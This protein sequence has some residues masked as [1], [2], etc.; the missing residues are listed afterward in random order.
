[1]CRIVLLRCCPTILALL[2]AAS[3]QTFQP[4]IP[5]AWNDRDVAGFETPLAY[6]DWSP[7]QVSETQYY[8]LKVRPICRTYPAYRPG[9]EPAGYVESLKQKEPEVIFDPAKLKTKEDWIRAGKLVFESDIVFFPAPAQFSVSG[10]AGP[11]KDGT[12]PYFVPRHRYV[13]RKKGVLETGFGSCAG[14]HTR[15]MPDGSFV[16]GAQG[17]VDPPSTE[18]MLDAIRTANAEQLRARAERAWALF[19]APWIADKEAFVLAPE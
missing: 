17:M 19:G 15:I 11:M 3:A 1:M 10:V 6:R 8:A 16:P 12:F 5:K 13:I 2:G 7:R 9:M 14:C 18:A 4:E